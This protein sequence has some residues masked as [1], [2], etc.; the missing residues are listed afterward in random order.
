M[1]AIWVDTDLGFDDL[2][3]ILLLRHLRVP[4]AG[5]SLV[6]G[7]ASLGRV[8]AN[9]LGAMK[10]YG[11]DFAVWRGADRPLVR[12]PETAERVLGPRGMMSRG[13]HLPDVSGQDVPAGAVA[14]LC[15]WVAARASHEPCEV[16]ALGPLTNLATLVTDAP[17]TT[18]QITR[19][20]WMGGSNGPGNHS[21]RAEFNALADPEAA[22]IVTEAGLPMEVVDLM[23][24]RQVT[25]GP[26]DLPRTDSLTADLLG[27]YLDIAL[28]RR[29][30]A[31]A[32]YDPLAALV[33]ARPSGFGVTPGDI[34]VDT[35]PG[36]SYGQTRFVPRAD[37]RTRLVVAPPQ[38]AAKQCLE[39]LRER[40]T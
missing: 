34:Q 39:A 28:S 30:S 19:L 29:R 13:R 5:I 32:I 11:F 4:V 23:V 21:A 16:L 14:A 2:W 7:N 31:M 3:A 20:V 17:Q 36:E 38:G 6:A 25:F 35:T 37:S 24:C 40:P 12:T 27:G 26:Q 1:T 9:A 15:D 22:R 8:V 10:A 33:A 18:R